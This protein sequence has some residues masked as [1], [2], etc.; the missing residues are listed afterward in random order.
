MGWFCAGFVKESGCAVWAIAHGRPE[1]HV[2]E[3]AIDVIATGDLTDAG[4]YV[5]AIG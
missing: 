3:H 4:N 1:G 2:E 5:I